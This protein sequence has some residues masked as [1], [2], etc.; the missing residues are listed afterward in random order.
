M[1]FIYQHQVVALK[2]AHCHR[3]VAIGVSKFGNFKNINVM[4]RKHPAGGVLVEHICSDI[5]LPELFKVLVCQAL[6][7]RNQNDAIRL[8]TIFPGIMAILQHIYMHEQCLTRTRSR[9]ESHLVKIG[10]REIRH[11]MISFRIGIETRLKICVNIGKQLL[12]VAEIFVE[13]YLRE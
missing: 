5:A 8:L 3:L 2:K 9:P 11:A 12:L 6:I 1:P 7:R 10:F 13:I 4:T